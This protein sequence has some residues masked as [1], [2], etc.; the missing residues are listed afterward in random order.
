[1]PEFFEKRF[2]S[3]P[4]KI[5]AS[6]ITFVFLIPYTAS[7]YNGLSRLFGMAFGN[8]SYTWCVLAMAVLTAV[9]VIL[10]GYTASAVNDFIQGIIMLVGI[11]AVIGAVLAARAGSLRRSLPSLRFRLR[12]PAS[13]RPCRGRTPRSSDR[14]RWGCSASSS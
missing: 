3:K 4:L 13:R 8:I 6:I 7:V 5:A 12:G 9:Y 11:C 2:G 1:M 10:G 14:T